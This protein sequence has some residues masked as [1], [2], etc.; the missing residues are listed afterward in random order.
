MQTAFERISRLLPGVELKRD[1]P[2]AEYTS[3]R[4]GGNASALLEASSAEEITAA[5]GVC[6]K[7]GV[8]V[9]I[10][11]N[12]TNLLVSDE[13]LDALIIRIADRMAG[14]ENDGGH[15]SCGAGLP[16][17]ALARSSVAKGYMGLEW[18]AGIPGNVG[19]AVTMNAGAY[20]G[21]ISDV[22]RSAEVLHGGNITKYI[23]S[24]GDFGYRRSPFCAPECIVIAA[25]FV[26]ERDDG[27]A[28]GRMREYN[29]R[30][31]EKQP[32]NYPSA[33]STFKRPEGHYAGALIESAGLKGTRV[34][35]AEVSNLHAGFIINA[36]GATSSDVYALMELVRARVL[37]E[38]GVLLEP[39]IRLMGRF[40][41]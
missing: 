29:L 38:S 21:Q 31:R 27:G 30:R 20:G 8:D 41:E 36:G 17:A 25:E 2:M 32:V 7:E 5:L 19:G 28:L 1:A 24:E 33:G 26:L 37:E 15:F 40:G 11:G 16:L 4:T 34:G 39:E 13:G 23:P 3:F 14:E 12:G 10:I 22:V 6:E 9:Y 18:A 35:G